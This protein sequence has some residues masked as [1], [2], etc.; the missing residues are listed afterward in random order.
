MNKPSWDNAPED[1]KFLAQ[2]RDGDWYWW[3]AKPIVMDPMS[4]W[5]PGDTGLETPA[6]LVNHSQN[7]E[8]W[9]ETLE[10]RP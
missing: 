8:S 9:K 2:D 3:S 1:A 6:L 4:Y 5:M 7:V 10:P